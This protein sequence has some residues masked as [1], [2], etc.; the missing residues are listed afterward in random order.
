M[1]VLTLLIFMEDNKMTTDE[2]IRPDIASAL[3]IPLHALFFHYQ[4]SHPRWEPFLDDMM[5]KYKV[6]VKQIQGPNSETQARYTVR[7]ITSPETNPIIDMSYDRQGLT[8]DNLDLLVDDRGSGVYPFRGAPD[9]YMW[10]DVLEGF[11]TNLPYQV[12]RHE[13]IPIF[14]MKNAYGMAEEIARRVFRSKQTYFDCIE[15]QR[16]EL[17]DDHR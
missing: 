8:I 1:L 15:L 11:V 3:K 5:G 16:R 10:D 17:Y 12:R 2:N 13:I 14:Q 7:L 4:N 6:S 9:P